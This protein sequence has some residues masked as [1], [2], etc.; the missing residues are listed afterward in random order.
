M[1]TTAIILASTVLLAVA[2]AKSLLH[3]CKPDEVLIF[4]GR[5]HRMAD[6]TTVGFRTITAGRGVRIPILEEVGRMDTSAI[7]VPMTVQG[8]YSEGGI[9]LSVQAVANVK[10]SRQPTLL[11]N[12]VERFLGKSRDEIA[13]IAK[14]TLEGHLRGVLATL[15]PEEVNQD[16]LKF[17][18]RLGVEASSDL[19]KLGIQLDLL[20]IQAVSDDRNYLDSIGRKRIAEIVRTA[21]IAESDATRTAEQAEAAAEARGNV[22]QAR[23]QAAVQRKAAEVREERARLEAVAKSR[24]EQAEQAGLEAQAQAEQK[25]HAMRAE[26]E[27]VRL[28]AD[29]TVPA[30]IERRVAELIAE[31]EAAPTAE[32][33]RAVAEAMATVSQAWQQCGPEAMD[34]VVAQRLPE[35][36]ERIGAAAT[37]AQASDV[38]VIGAGDGLALGGAVRAYP[39]AIAS[40]LSEVEAALGVD[41]GSLMRGDS[42]TRS[43]TA[44]QA[45][46]AGSPAL[47]APST[48]FHHGGTD[49]G[50]VVRAGA[51]NDN[52]NHESR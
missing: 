14:E 21:E 5:S 13:R 40:L 10:I 41:V 36:V 27:R 37:A 18:E 45:A 26:L 19:S 51:H 49:S 24:E 48:G 4:S 44:P 28:Q 46:H 25:L 32:R 3:V 1:I 23:A 31:A 20:K 50:T 8:A 6:G 34:M 35:I 22:A 30:E 7:S 39:A 15:T 42:A 43:S 11:N 52:S 33:G 29:V 9:P 47:P 16:R 12:A 2:I 38:S 17:A